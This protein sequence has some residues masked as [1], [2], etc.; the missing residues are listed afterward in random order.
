MDMTFPRCRRCGQGDLVPLSDFG[1]QGAPIHFKAW[2]CSNPE[3]LFNIKIRNGEIIINEPVGDG[4]QHAHSYRSMRDN[5]RDNQRDP[6]RQ[7]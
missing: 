4:S 7:P 5:Q 3:C 2:V 6:Q 1:S